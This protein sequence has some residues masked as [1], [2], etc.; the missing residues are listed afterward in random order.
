MSDW[1]HPGLWAKALLYARRAT[2]EE[3][4]SP[5]YPLWSALALEFIARSCLAKIHPV[6]LADATADENVFHACGY[7]VSS[8]PRSI[9]ANK[10]LRRCRF[11]VKEFTEDDFKAAMNLIERRNAELHSGT[12]GFAGYGTEM[13]LSDFFRICRLLLVAQEKKLADLLGT[14]EGA[15]AEKMIAAAEEKVVG[16]VKKAI[17]EARKRFELLDGGAREEQQKA[18]VLQ[19]KV[20]KGK[21]VDCPA[22]GCKAMVRGEKVSVN[23]PQ[24]DDETGPL[25]RRALIL[26]TSLDCLC[27][28]LSLRGHGALHAAGLG[29]SYEVVEEI[30]PAEYF[31]IEQPSE[32]DMEAYAEQ[33]MRDLADESRDE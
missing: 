23:K 19:L 4:S 30:D 14:E 16:V 9:P 18:A 1:S 25:F 6:L 21:A 26:P 8:V 29:G 27:C 2:E 15:A 33:W 22:C 7:P 24:V 13:W 3:R 28:K 11:V 10:V 17:A 20:S 32:E 31:G 12:S 5:L